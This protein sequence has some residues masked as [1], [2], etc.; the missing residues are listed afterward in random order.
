LYV[1]V[2][3]QKTNGLKALLYTELQHLVLCLFLIDV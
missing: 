1:G 2:L 3:R